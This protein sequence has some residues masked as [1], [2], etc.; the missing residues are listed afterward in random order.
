M[1]TAT[2]SELVNLAIAQEDAILA[3]RAEKKRKAPTPV[4]SGQPQRFRMVPPTAPQRAP[5]QSGCWVA[6][7]PQ[8]TTPRFPP[9]QQQQGPRQNVQPPLR[10]GGGYT[11]F[12]C[13]SN[14][15]L[16]KDCPQGKQQQQPNP[17]GNPPKKGK[18]QQ[19]QV[20]QGRINFTTLAELP[21]GA[22]VMMGT[23]L[24]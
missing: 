21:Q 10:L 19:V 5:P 15:H 23:F 7:S 2:Y 20:R 22:P 16:I 4:P 6:R 9:P 11:C 13:G 1:R 17:R 18:Q 14:R 24:I 12:Q 8:Q 3:H